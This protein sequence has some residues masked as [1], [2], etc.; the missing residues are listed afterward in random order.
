M[1]P[2]RSRTK[3]LDQEIIE[4]EESSAE[5]PMP[6]VRRRG[7]AATQHPTLSDFKLGYAEEKR[8]IVNQRIA[9][10]K[11]KTGFPSFAPVVHF[12]VGIGKFTHDS[13]MKDGG[14]WKAMPGLLSI[15]EDNQALTSQQLAMSLL[16]QAQGQLS[17]ILIFK[18]QILNLKKVFGKN[19]LYPAVSP[20]RRTSA[21]FQKNILTKTT[22]A[23]PISIEDVNI[24]TVESIIARVI[25]IPRMHFRGPLSWTLTTMTWLLRRYGFFT[26]CRS[27]CCRTN[28]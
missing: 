23:A 14:Q 1:L 5:K 15:D 22:S 2:E 8:Q 21:R 28:A 6:S 24:D 12:N 4:I 9:D 7:A 20:Q 17:R 3:L 16:S 27:L 10:K 11:S 26:A 18:S 13:L 19:P 25:I